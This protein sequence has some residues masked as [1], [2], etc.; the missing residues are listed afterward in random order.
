MFNIN[1]GR[2]SADAVAGSA[3]TAAGIE[4]YSGPRPLD[5]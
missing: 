5:L 4:A 3:Q 2:V 1:A